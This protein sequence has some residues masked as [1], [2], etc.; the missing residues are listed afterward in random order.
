MIENDLIK[1]FNFLNLNKS[2]FKKFIMNKKKD[3]DIE[4]T[5]L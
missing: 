2:D 3:G 1:S 5:I 4:M